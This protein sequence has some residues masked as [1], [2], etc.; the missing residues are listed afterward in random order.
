MKALWEL[1]TLTPGATLCHRRG[2]PLGLWDPKG[3]W[4][5]GSE[6]IPHWGASAEV[7]GGAGQPKFQVIRDLTRNPGAGGNMPMEV[8]LGGHPEGSCLC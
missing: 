7:A 6:Q 4:A 3:P 5:P 8:P 1:R 2:I